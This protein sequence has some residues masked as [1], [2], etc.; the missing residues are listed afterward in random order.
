MCDPQVIRVG[1]LD[2]QVC[3]PED[4]TDDQASEFT[5][6]AAPTGI[7]NGWEMKKTGN[8]TLAGDPERVKCDDRE[9]YVH[10]MFEC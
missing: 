9:H 8:S 2:V 5:N 4:W 3:V 6:Q 10:I 1:F 7:S